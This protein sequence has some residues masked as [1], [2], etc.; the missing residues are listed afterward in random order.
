MYWYNNDDFVFTPTQTIQDF[1]YDD[2]LLD[3]I[4]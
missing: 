3:E 2:V 1:L 4:F